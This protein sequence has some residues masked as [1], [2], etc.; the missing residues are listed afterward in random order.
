MPWDQG[1]RERTCLSGNGVIEISKTKRL[2]VGMISRDKEHS[3]KT[4]RF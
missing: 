4:L 2:E 1:G 3:L